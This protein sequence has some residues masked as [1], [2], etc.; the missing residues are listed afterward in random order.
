[1]VDGNAH[2]S[3]RTVTFATDNPEIREFDPAQP[4]ECEISEPT[5]PTGWLAA[6]EGSILARSLKVLTQALVAGEARNASLGNLSNG[7]NIKF[8][9]GGNREL[10]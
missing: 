9:G 2:V 8:S 7:S 4:I 1:M 3:H 6:G 5:I 10:H